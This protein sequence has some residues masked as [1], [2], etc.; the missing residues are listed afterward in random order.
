M[1]MT[2]RAIIGSEVFSLALELA[3]SGSFVS[4]DEV[5]HAVRSLALDSRLLWDDDALAVLDH[6]CMAALRHLAL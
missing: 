1:S 3:D 6:R 5:V 2:D 4:G